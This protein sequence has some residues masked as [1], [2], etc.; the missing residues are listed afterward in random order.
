M[1]PNQ[2]ETA[3]GCSLQ[4]QCFFVVNIGHS[5]ILFAQISNSGITFHVTNFPLFLFPPFPLPL[6]P[7]FLLPLPLSSFPLP[8]VEKNRPQLLGWR[9]AEILQ[10]ASISQKM[11]KAVTYNKR[12]IL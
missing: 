3:K 6:S 10:Y 7:S 12:V 5:V 11:M 9:V 2:A 1:R 8:L 4:L